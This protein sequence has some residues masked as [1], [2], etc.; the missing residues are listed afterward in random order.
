MAW[1]GPSRRQAFGVPCCRGL[2]A[3]RSSS[4]RHLSSGRACNPDRARGRL[5]PASGGARFA[6]RIPPACVRGRARPS[7]RVVLPPVGLAA[8]RP[9]SPSVRAAK[10]TDLAAVEQEA[11]RI[12]RGVLEFSHRIDQDLCVCRRPV[13]ELRLSGSISLSVPGPLLTVTASKSSPARG[14]S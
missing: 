4:G 6:S 3:A 8:A 2:S 5:Q 12:S 7:H 13:V 9:A 10:P 1:P 11:L 14:V